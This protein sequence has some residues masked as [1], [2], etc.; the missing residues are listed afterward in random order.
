MFIWKINVIRDKVKNGP[1]ILT[2]YRL[3]E[4]VF[5]CQIITGGNQISPHEYGGLTPSVNWTMIESIKRRRHPNT[6]KMME[7]CRII[8]IDS[9]KIYYNKRTF[10]IENYPFMIHKAGRSTGCI[11]IKEDWGKAKRVLNQAFKEGMI[12]NVL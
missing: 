6:G 8:P 5:E 3:S 12:I 7:M 2:A 11:A 10:G 9:G 4:N 1:G